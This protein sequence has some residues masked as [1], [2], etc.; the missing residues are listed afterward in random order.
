MHDGF[1]KIGAAGF[2]LVL[3]IAA[4]ACGSSSKSSS[5]SGSG[6]VT[7]AAKVACP[8][9]P[10]K[11]FSVATLSAGL[12][13]Q[14]PAIAPGMKAAADAANN[15]CEAGVP[16]ETEVCDDKLD[17]N[18]AAACGRQIVQ[19]KA[20]AV[21][22]TQSPL[23]DS[24]GPITEAA[25]IP[26][27]GSN[28][29]STWA[30][31][32]TTAFPLFQS[33]SQY[34]GQL[35]VFAALDVKSVA[36]AYIDIPSVVGIIAVAKG[37]LSDLGVKLAKTVPIPPNATDFSQYA[38]QVI[39]SGADGLSVVLGG[40]QVVQLVEAM[41]QQGTTPKDIAVVAGTVALKP[42]DIAPTGGKLDGLYGVSATIPVSDTSNAGVAQYLQELKDSGATVAPADDGFQAWAFVHEVAKMLKRATTK[43]AAGLLAVVK[44]STIDSPGLPAVDFTK[45]A[46]PEDPVLGKV[47][48]FNRQ[49]AISQV[50]NNVYV[51]MSD[52][53]VDQMSVDDIR[54]VV[55]K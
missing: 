22:G 32:G 15:S 14:S 31:K 29:S 18:V 27:I 47:R 43:D 17:P 6:S 5:P 50:T 37:R 4:A 55:K 48:L 10:V 1:K 3:V 20:A 53:F 40:S 46:V 28:G 33:I 2:A 23:A 35:T 44:T 12:G 25:G 52:K 13:T 39:N 45:N 21:V 54:A 11:L 7:T 51:P 26:D 34:Y 41:D 19:E 8:G 49:I 16:I 9:T 42:S 38:A 24:Y 36:I 30:T